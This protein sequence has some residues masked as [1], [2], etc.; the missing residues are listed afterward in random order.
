MNEEVILEQAKALGKL[1]D[2]EY[3]RFKSLL[4]SKP[5]VCNCD[6]ESGAGAKSRGK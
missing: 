2:V 4:T 3:D 5:P 1:N 6:C